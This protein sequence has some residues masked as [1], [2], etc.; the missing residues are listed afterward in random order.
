MSGGGFQAVILA[1]GLGTRLR[2]LTWEIPK[3]MVPV[4]D[5][6]FLEHQIALLKDQGAE[7]I[8]LLIGYLGEQIQD[9]F[10]DGAAFG[11]PITYHREAQP[12]GTGGA[13][14]EAREQLRETFLILYGDSYLP[15]DHSALHAQLASPRWDAVTV[16]Y[17]NAE[18]T[19]VAENLALG[20]D[21]QVLLYLKGAED[22]RLT[23]VEA[24][25]NAVRRSALAGLPE[26]EPFSLEQTLFPR[27]IAAGRLGA[28][29][30]DQRFYDIGTPSRLEAIR[31]RLGR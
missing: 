4:G 19:D 6:P 25:V 10:G 30:T 17:D 1:G 27:L 11:I 24:G 2:P 29:V 26:G 14:M 31:A 28:H 15:I 23:H 5:R 13:V 22:P 3:P 20:D 8:L 9:H 7:E 12:M 18:H 16:A 21:G